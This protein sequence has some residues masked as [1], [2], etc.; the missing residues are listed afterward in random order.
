M[1]IGSVCKGLHIG[2][3]IPHSQNIGKILISLYKT[4]I[5]D[6]ISLVPQRPYIKEHQHEKF[7]IG[8]NFMKIYVHMENQY[9]FMH[10]TCKYMYNINM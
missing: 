1:T 4:I 3:Q 7:P 8:A 9:F 2:Q 5:K 6:I 10:I